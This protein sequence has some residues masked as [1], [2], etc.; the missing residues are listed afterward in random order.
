MKL[1]GETVTIVA[2]G[3][4]DTD[5][6]ALGQVAHAD[7]AKPFEPDRIR[8]GVRVAERCRDEG[9]YRDR[10]L[11]V[12]QTRLAVPVRNGR[13]VRLVL[14]AALP[15]NAS[16]ARARASDGGGAGAACVELELAPAAR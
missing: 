4:T 1:T 16:A 13:R 10:L 8:E 11:W 9:V 2:A 7:I 15:G 6:H 12:G 14:G 5:V 3:R